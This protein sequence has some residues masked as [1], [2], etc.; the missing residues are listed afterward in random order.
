M[1]SAIGKVE[2]NGLLC[3]NKTLFIKLKS[4][5]NSLTSGIGI[6]RKKPGM[7]LKDKQETEG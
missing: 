7:I 3:Y 2:T 6:E 5:H 1:K 4:K